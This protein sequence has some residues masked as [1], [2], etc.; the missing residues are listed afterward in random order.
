MT[1]ERDAFAWAVNA[2]AE[3]ASAL[4]APYRAVALM[5]EAA[6]LIAE[7]GALPARR[8]NAANFFR[9]M[10]EEAF[11]NAPFRVTEEALQTWNEA[12]ANRGIK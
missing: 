8:D 2:L 3:G 10:I 4:P 9:R 1:M 7:D 6:R 12:M 11:D 5:R